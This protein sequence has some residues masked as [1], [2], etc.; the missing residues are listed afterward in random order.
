MAA[1]PSRALASGSTRSITGR[2]PVCSQNLASRPS[3][4]REPIV[5][6]ITDSC[7]KKILVSSAGGASPLVAPEM[8]IRPPGLS[9][10]T[11]CAQ[12]AW[13]TVSITTSTRSGSLAP[14]ANT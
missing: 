1:K 13:P 3:W 6:P 2:A 9:D 5:D 8:T 11:E 4:S 10:R 14:A 7:V 12:V